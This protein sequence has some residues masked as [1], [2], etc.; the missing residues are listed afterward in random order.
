[1]TRQRQN[2][3]VIDNARLVTREAEFHGH[4]LVRDGMIAEIGEGASGVANALDLEGGYLLPG[5]IELHTDNL[6]K[7]I[8][9]R[10][11][12]RW[13]TAAAVLAHDAQIAAAGITTVFDAL[14][15]GE[16]RDD[17][18]RS[19]MLLDAVKAIREAGEN[20]LFRAEHLL[21]MRCE[22]AHPGVVETFELFLDDPL[23]RLVSLMDH[24]PGQRQFASIEK[25]QEYYQ[26][27]FG[28]TEQE[29]EQLRSRWL[30]QQR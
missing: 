23:V 5:L 20:G 1:M 7:H 11:G 18:L 3:L 30:E 6:E 8:A 27:R 29:L 21:H 22:V 28:Y 9:P 2:D 14:A 15:V 4:L 10:P 12:V 17:F 16:S 19:E 24:T 25:F 26:G 13:P